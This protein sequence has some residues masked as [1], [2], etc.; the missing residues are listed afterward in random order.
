MALCPFL[1][2]ATEISLEARLALTSASFNITALTWDT[3][4]RVRRFETKRHPEISDISY[5][6]E[7]IPFGCN[8]TD[9]ESPKVLNI[10]N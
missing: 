2:S 5:F 4:S 10:C 6:T 7:F 3:V 9:Y 8:T 1:R